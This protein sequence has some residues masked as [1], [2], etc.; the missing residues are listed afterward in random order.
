MANV[1]RASDEEVLKDMSSKE[2]SLKKKHITT[3]TL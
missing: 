3:G 2:E 1:T